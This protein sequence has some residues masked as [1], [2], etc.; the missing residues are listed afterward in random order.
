M[1]PTSGAR[2]RQASV[3]CQEMQNA[4]PETS[5]NLERLSNR[6]A[7]DAGDSAG[8][9][10]RGACHL[11]HEA[12]RT[13]PHELRPIDGKGLVKHLEA[14]VA[15][16]VHRHPRDKHRAGHKKGMLEERAGDNERHHPQHGDERIV[17]EEAVEPGI[18][19]LRGVEQRLIT[20]EIEGH[21][22]E[23]PLR[24]RS[25]ILGKHLRCQLSPDRLLLRAAD[26]DPPRS[27]LDPLG[28]PRLQR[29]PIERDFNDRKQ[30]GNIGAP[31]TGHAG[32]AEERGH[33]QRP[34]LDRIAKGSD[35][36]VH[37]LILPLATGRRCGGGRQTHRTRSRNAILARRPAGIVLV[38]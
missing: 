9:H 29:L 23:R 11:G 4:P 13:M 36:G 38:A 19:F 17:G 15:G 30:G 6:A 24:S 8:E 3:N 32:R 12:G 1:K 25:L 14:D 37:G 26:P 16:D 35:E 7:K 10:L 33:Q 20:T 18:E 34:T 31:H 28:V 2:V 27:I 22:V 21:G 5:E